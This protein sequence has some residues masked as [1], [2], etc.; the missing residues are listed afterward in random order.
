MLPK[1]MILSDIHGGYNNLD[2]ALAYYEEKNFERLFVLGDLFG[3]SFDD[4]DDEILKRLREVRNSVIVRGNCDGFLDCEDIRQLVINGTRI[5]LTHG[6]R[7]NLMSLVRTDAD[8]IC[9]GH[10]HIP[11]IREY[12]GKIIINPGSVARSR[13]GPESFATIEDGYIRI[14]SLDYE[15]LEEMKCFA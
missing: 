5:T 14:R 3:Y 6:H 4:T 12:A 11:V 1:I 7:H 9:V 8:I 15:V 13:S 10:S 2:R